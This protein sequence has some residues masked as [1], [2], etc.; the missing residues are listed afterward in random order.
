MLGFVSLLMDISSEMIHSLLPVFI[1][2]VLG[3]TAS[4][5]GL[6]KGVAE[7]TALIVKVF[8]GCCPIFGAAQ[9]AGRAGLRTGAVS[10]PLFAMAPGAGFV[11][12]A[13][14]GHWRHRSSH[15]RSAARGRLSTAAT[16]RL[17]RHSLHAR[18]SPCQSTAASTWPE[19]TMAAEAKDIRHPQ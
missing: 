5:V 7:A 1:V 19:P 4:T 10:K 17:Q 18:A 11:L 9:A 15:G 13:R 3:A 2:T 6:I 8:R 14:A 16:S 12:A